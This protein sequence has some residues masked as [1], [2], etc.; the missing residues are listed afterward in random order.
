MR[1]PITYSDEQIIR[2]R[3]L[4]D[5]YEK[6][7]SLRIQTPFNYHYRP[8]KPH[9]GVSCTIP[10]QGYTVEEIKQTLKST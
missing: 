2:A 4:Y 1:K 8:N 5:N 9:Y 10:G 3:E 7:R 6:L